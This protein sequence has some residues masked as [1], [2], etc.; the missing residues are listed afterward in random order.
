MPGVSNSLG[1]SFMTSLMGTSELLRIH[2]ALLMAVL[3]MY[4]FTV[5]TGSTCCFSHSFIPLWSDSLMVE[6]IKK[7]QYLTTIYRSRVIIGEYSQ[8]RIRD[9]YLPI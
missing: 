6:S 8:R 1:Y 3:P 5:P 2:S 4:N 7:E 9:V